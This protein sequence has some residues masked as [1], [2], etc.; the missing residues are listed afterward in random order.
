M[1]R[2]ARRAAAVPLSAA[3]S[4]AV[5]VPF[6]LADDPPAQPVTLT[7]FDF[8]AGADG[9]AGT[10]ASCSFLGLGEP[11]GGCT[12]SNDRN[13]TDKTA[14]TSFSPLLNAEEALVGVGTQQSPSFTVPA[15]A[16]TGTAALR[17]DRRATFDAPLLDAGSRVDW[18][19][20]LVNVTKD[21]TQAPVRLLDEELTDSDEARVTRSVRVDAAHLREGDQYRLRSTARF[22]SETAQLVDG[23]IALAFDNVKL[24]VEPP[25]KGDDG[26]PGTPGADG[27]KGDTGATG[28]TGEKGATGQTGDKGSTGANGEPGMNGMPGSIGPTGMPGALGVPGPPGEVRTIVQNR[29][30]PVR[31]NS[32][33]ARRLLRLDRLTT[34]R[35]KGPFANQL[36]LRVFCRSAVLSRC[37]GTIKLRTLRP[38]NVALKKGRKR[39]KKVTL[40]TG[41]YQLTRR[42][43]GYGKVFLTPVGRKLVKA[44]APIAVSAQVTVLDQQ[45]RQQRLSRTFR[46]R[47]G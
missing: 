39:M 8:D 26:A 9:W 12:V 3:V 27:E 45:G 38:I 4:A 22:T 32:A 36:R 46:V 30:V 19:F 21:T 47:L 34:V 42:Q 15:G 43:T 1:N 18:A 6:A 16:T 40:G 10:E 28:D 5:L 33:E 41:S 7:S 24:A 20:E 23:Q 14:Q 25:L 13:A 29:T 37:E 31:V 44:R 11:P 2:M 17:V 35:F